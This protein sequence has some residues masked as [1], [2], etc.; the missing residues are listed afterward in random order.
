MPHGTRRIPSRAPTGSS[1]KDEISWTSANRQESDEEQLEVT[2]SCIHPDQLLH[3]LRFRDHQMWEHPK[4][5]FR[6]TLSHSAPP[7]SGESSSAVRLQNNL[8][9]VP[10]CKLPATIK[11]LG[12]GRFENIT[13]PSPLALCIHIALPLPCTLYISWPCCPCML[14]RLRSRS[15][16]CTAS[17]SRERGRGSP[18]MHHEALRP[19]TSERSLSNALSCAEI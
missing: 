9:S 12:I 11:L 6:S 8:G 3:G 2:M 14:P 5:S 10:S 1:R 13:L 18:T 17:S 7:I 4:P 19:D 16:R 15:G